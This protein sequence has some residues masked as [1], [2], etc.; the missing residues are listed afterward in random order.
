MWRPDLHPL[1][2]RQS[3]AQS[4][5]ADGRHSF[6]VREAIPSDTVLEVSLCVEVPVDVVDQNPSLR[7]FVLTGEMEIRQTAYLQTF[8]SS[9]AHT[10]C[11]FADQ[12]EGYIEELAEKVLCFLSPLTLN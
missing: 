10:A 2:C 1:P 7:G 11:V 8:A 4:T 6:W 3:V 9:R 12:D 5:G